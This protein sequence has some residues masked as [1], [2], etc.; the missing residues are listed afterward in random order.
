MAQEIP[1][2]WVQGATCSGCVVSVLNGVSPDITHLL[3]Q[4]LVPGKHVSLRFMPTVM[5][6]TGELAMRALDDASAES[7]YLLIVEGSVQVGADGAYCMTGELDGHERS[8]ASEVE[9][10]A[11]KAM[12]VIALGT[13]ASYGGIPAA[14]PNPTGAT[15]VGEFLADKKIAVP[16]INIPGCPPHPDRFTGVIASILMRG[17]PEADALDDIGRPKCFY[18]LIHE[19]CE[20]RPFFD[21]GKF[22]QKPGDDGCLYLVGCKGP[23][24]YAD[25]PIRKWNGG[26][27]WPVENNSPCLGCTEPGF[28]DAMSP[29]YTKISDLDDLKLTF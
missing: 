15:S 14:D 2:V 7:G 12:A 18:P 25:C 19:N 1:A 20:R 16:L 11:R 21:A 9:R 29:F 3:L 6:G 23:V 27:N 5:A 17:L 13:C 10:L 28:P 26:R 8:F 22:A 24:T 4:Q